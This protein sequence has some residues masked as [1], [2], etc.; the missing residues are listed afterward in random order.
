MNVG[1]RMENVTADQEPSRN[2]GINGARLR[3]NTVVDDPGDSR[4]LGIN[5]A[6]S[7]MKNL[8][9]DQE[10]SLK[11]RTS[12]ARQATAFSSCAPACVLFLFDLVRTLFAGDGIKSSSTL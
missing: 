8:A 6:R 12:D 2:L 7:R 9:A 3:M 11:L 4:N 5:D 10:R 1:P